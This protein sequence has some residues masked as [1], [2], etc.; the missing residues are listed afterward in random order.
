MVSLGEGAGLQEVFDFGRE[1]AEVA[2]RAFGAP[3]KMEFEK[4][5][6]P[7]LLMSKKRY[8]GLAWT[9]PDRPDKLD[10]KGIETVRRDWCL[11][12]RQV[13]EHCLHLLLQERSPGRATEYVRET[14]AALRQ[15]RVDP[16]LLVV[17]KAL[18]RDGAEAYDARQAHVELAEKL[19]QRDPANAPKVGDRV[20]YVFLVGQAG[21]PAY[22]RAED[23]LWAIEHDLQI[24]AD[25]YI[26]HQLKAP[27]LRIFGPVLAG[28][29]ALEQRLFA[30][31]H[32]R[33]VVR[34][35]PSNS[36]LAAFARKRAKCLGCRSLLA[37]GGGGVLCPDCRTE[38]RAP[39]VALAQ[40]E[41][42]RP[43]EFEASQ[44]ST[45]AYILYTY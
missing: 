14:V 11:L 37:D 28:E 21:A 31:E 27:L 40:V 23:P 1:A 39:K 35:A 7:Y 26:E 36:P 24:D 16:R 41:A 43:L 25:Y 44:L 22:S 9:R 42:M 4:V 6:M 32:T 34:G 2:T 15:G 8:A 13:V 45:Y 17:S 30:G 19:R 5:Y 12:V 33:R 3:V 38:E 18:V 20:P 10:A 29:G